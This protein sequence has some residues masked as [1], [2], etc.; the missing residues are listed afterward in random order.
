MLDVVAIVVV[1]VDDGHVAVNLDAVV[2]YLVLTLCLW[3][4]LLLLT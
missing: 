2:L 1:G 4:F 3:L